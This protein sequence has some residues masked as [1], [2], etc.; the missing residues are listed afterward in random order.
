M[1][2]SAQPW[3][4]LIVTASSPSQGTAYQ[5]QL[6]LRRRLGLLAGVRQALV[7]PDAGGRRIGSG[8]STLLCLM[9]IL[10]RELAQT[11]ERL[12]DPAAWEATLRRLRILI[13]HGGGDSKRLPAYGPCGKV[14]VPVPSET[15]S[16]VPASLFDRQ[17]PVYLALPPAPPGTGQVVITAGDVL[18]V[19]DPSQVRFAAGGV[20]GLGCYATPEQAVRHGVFCAGPDG[21]VERF[22]Q[23]PSPAEQQAHGAVN[24]YGQAILDIGV[25]NFDAATAVRLLRAAGA[26]PDAHGRLAWSGPLGDAI[27]DAGLDF[28]REICCAM[29]EQAS[30]DDYIASARAAGS[31]WDQAMLERL[32]DA[33]RPVP[34]HVQV[35]PQCRFLHF[36]T[37]RQLITSGI[38]LVMQDRGISRARQPLLINNDVAEAG[39]AG[40]GDAWVEGCRL[41]AP[42]TLGGENVVVGIDVDEPLDLAPGAC[43]DVLG[44]RDRSGAD[45]WFTRF[46]GVADTF[47]DRADGDATFCGRPVLEWLRAAGARPDDVWD[48]S[49]PPEQRTV[50][51]ARLFPADPDP[52]AYRRWPALFDPATAPAATRAAWL[53]SDRYSACEVADLADQDAFAERRL[54]VRAHE[55]GQSLGRMFRH[56]SGFSAADLASVL[57]HVERPGAV[58]AAALAE[59]R[60]HFEGAAAPGGR[61]AFVFS[62]IIHTLGSAVG[63]LDGADARPPAALLPGLGEALPPALAN[64]MDGLGLGIAGAATAAAWAAKARAVAFR[65]FGRSIVSSA[66]PAGRLPR[67][68]LRT[69]EI[70]WGRAPARLDMGGG[71]T[72]T[73]PYC[74]EN[75]GCVL[76]TAVTLNGQPPIHAY[77][78]MV[79]EPVIRIASIDGGTRVEVRDLADL[80]D[81]ADATA[82]FGLA[83]AAL[84]LSGLSPAAAPWPEGVTLERM[85]GQFGGGI[86]LTTLAAIPKGS[87][88]GTSSIMGAVILAVVQRLMGR[89]LTPREL[90][91]GVLRLEQALT[92]GGGWQDQI[93]GAV[94]GVKVITT[95]PGLVPDASIHY[96]PPDVLDPQTNGGTTLLY[97]TGI[98]RL[99]KNLL[100]EVVGRYLDRDRVAT[101]ALRH[102]HALPPL[103]AD[104]MARRDRAE[105][106]RW[107]DV[108]WRLNKTLDP[109]STNDAVEAILDRIG[110]HIHGAKLLGAGGG[111]FLLMVCRSSEDA[112]RIRTVLEAEPPN[113]R[114]RFFDFAVSREGLV[115]TV[116]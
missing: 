116:C 76:N 93:G 42:L 68:A 72:D 63:R 96:V 100:R 15:D 19:F 64:W 35:L 106:G 107:I 88:L 97:Y 82:E 99:A 45:V 52:A 26:A 74:L 28:Y 55:V 75:G 84:A 95:G 17:A 67:G 29:G 1:H 3:D 73:P 47:K 34:F 70:V 105:F 18:L 27:A 31:A 8:G 77:A 111:G 6:R 44:G 54:R 87:G 20:T 9:D 7:V 11:P 113:D 16:A 43:L 79:P 40:G 10:A 110:P 98:T 23:K 101:A 51:N 32:F 71:W 56:E 62:R 50:W 69:D 66:G 114:A 85:L 37:T 94:G 12:A 22:L 61:E 49:L 60:W 59:A 13:L 80:L 81:F 14:F 41:R 83:K 21:R 92:T 58:V 36:G 30:R 33:L 103:V 48:A 53:R 39:R 109:D 46:Y 102:L 78:R 65:H 2:P 108:T 4:Y 86:E 115:V 112:A 89:D 91:H 24:R 25:M 38:D 104:A 90:F 5:E 57:G